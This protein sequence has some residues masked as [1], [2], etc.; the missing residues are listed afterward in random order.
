MAQWPAA[1]SRLGLGLRDVEEGSLLESLKAFLRDKH[2]LLLL[3]NF[4][5]VLGAAP[6]LVE[7]LLACPSLKIL[8]TSR[9]VL[10]VEGEYEFSVPP[11][12]LPDPLHLPS[13]EELLQYGAVALF[14]QRAQAVKPNFALSED[15][16]AAL[17]QICI[18][19]DG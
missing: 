8:V 5:Q 9:A 13:P 4:E 11:L 2:L 16:A 12:S 15:N 3:D 6:S 18:Q 1:L 7:L 19:L 14:V 10:H 17:A